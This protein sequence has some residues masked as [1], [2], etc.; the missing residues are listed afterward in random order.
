MDNDRASARLTAV[1]VGILA[2]MLLGG[3]EIG[4]S[5][6]APSSAP[7][8]AASAAAVAASPRPEVTA[9]PTATPL[10]EVGVAPAGSWGRL[11]WIHRGN[12]LPVG[13][14]NVNAFG[15]S[16]GFVAVATSGGDDGTG[17]AAPFAVTSIGSAD[18]LHWSAE[19]SLDA[20][21]LGDGVEI[22]GLF[23]GP[24]GLLLVGDAS[25]GAC[26]GP[27][28]VSALWS[29]SDGLAWRRLPLPKDF[30]SSRVETLDGGAA[31]Y[32]ATGPRS[33]GKTPGIWLSRDG[34][35]WSSLSLPSVSSGTVVV[36]NATSFD[37]G[38]VLAGAVLGP[39]GGCGGA[40]SVHPSLWW[41]ADGGHWTRDSF[42]GGSSAPD[43]SMTI[44]RLSDRT[45][46]A[47]EVTSQDPALR[48]WISD[49]GRSW[50]R[51]SSPSSL[52]ERPLI[53]DGRH[54]A[55]VLNPDSGVGPPSVTVIDH[56][57]T[58]TELAQRGDGPIAAEDSV[59]WTAAVGPT[60]I[61]VVS[62]DG[63]SVWLGVP[64]GAS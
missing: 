62:V 46:V 14:T 16:G 20:T 1:G 55:L 11:D 50:Q 43:A 7:P 41:S 29:S 26:G 3:C 8:V 58:L 17:V 61:L 10:P 39:E 52:I 28:W 5:S 13:P 19:R 18:G 37:G 31:G 59:P 9:S 30:R 6:T 24:A 38:L 15:W 27:P 64:T 36:N 48:A 21:G 4:R 54:A 40:S 51:V 63:R 33:D 32:I 35:T 42:T 60:G 23:E 34:S 45:L 44:R 2:I 49:D 53:T 56:Q 57:L 22:A 12:A 25:P 47:I